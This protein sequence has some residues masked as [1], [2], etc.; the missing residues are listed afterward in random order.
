MKHLYISLL[1]A[2]LSSSLFFGCQKSNVPAEPVWKNA[3][4]PA[5]QIVRMSSKPYGLEI[6]EDMKV[7]QANIH[8][9]QLVTDILK[10]HKIAKEIISEIV[11]KSKEIFDLQTAKAGSP[12]TLIKDTS[13]SVHY[14]IYEKDKSEFIVCDL[15]EGAEGIKVYRKQQEVVTKH[16]EVA[17]RLNN[18]VENS[19]KAAKVNMEIMPELAEI[20]KWSF[21]FFK[22]K[23]GDIFKVIYDEQF[24]NGKPF[25]V[26]AVYAVSFLHDD[27]E[28]Q[29][30]RYQ[31]DD[32]YLYFDEKGNCLKKGFLKAP[33]K[34]SRISSGFTNARY[35]PI[36]HVT[37]AHHGID[38]AAPTGTPIMS[39]GSGTVIEMGYKGGNGNYV[40]VQHDKTFT[41][42]Y[43][44]MSK[45]PKELK[46][47]QKVSQGD[48]IG[49]VGS[50]GLATGP[51]LCFR[52]WK[53]GVQVNPATIPQEHFVGEEVKDKKGF[54]IYAKDMKTRLDEL[55][56]YDADAYTVI[57]KA[58][59]IG[60]CFGLSCGI[61]RGLGFGVWGLG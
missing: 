44:H 27:K 20:L 37:R 25:A 26:S 50:T 3:M 12:V 55:Q 8:K 18:S 36:L 43:L 29:A 9:N 14:V 45:F 35:H 33:L 13:E 49:Y 53:N 32:K 59:R 16:Q 42:Q 41:S 51:H 28:Y 38:Y 11:N 4:L 56:Y 22:V 24:V 52:F 7:I 17:I 48:V 23:R 2:S 15:R 21:D 5:P 34:Y 39:I 10:K 54:L 30:F 19:L 60:V 6:S 46:K 1:V 57:T 31:Q 40:K 61:D 47:G 58:E